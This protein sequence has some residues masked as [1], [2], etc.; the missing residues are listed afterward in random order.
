MSTY[1]PFR[2]WL[3]FIVMW[4]FVADIALQGV[5]AVVAQPRPLDI[6]IDFGM[7]ILARGLVRECERKR[8][9]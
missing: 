5:I 9:I 4:I 2:H 7:F 1:S 3:Y 6:L 8:R